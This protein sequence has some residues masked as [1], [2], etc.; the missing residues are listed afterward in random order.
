ML[1]QKSRRTK[2][3]RIFRIFVPNFAPKF[4]SKFFEEFSCFVSWETETRKNSL[5]IPAIFQCK[6]PRQMRKK[7][8]RTFLERRQSNICQSC[9]LARDVA[10]RAAIYRS[11]Q[12][13]Q[14]RNAKNVSRKSF[15][16]SAKKM[17]KT[18]KKEEEILTLTQKPLGEAKGDR[19][20]K[21]TKNVKK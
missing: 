9:C 17:A 21:V 7:I 3:S 15:G 5:K 1:G 18:P 6:I 16:W 19:Q 4:C 2:V 11:L 20:K 8:H 12:T 10:T 14:A 13:L